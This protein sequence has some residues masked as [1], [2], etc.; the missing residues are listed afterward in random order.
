MHFLLLGLLLPFVLLL[1]MLGMERVERSLGNEAVVAHLDARFETAQR[2]EL[3]AVVS[4]GAGP[5][6]ENY[7]NRRRLSGLLLSRSQ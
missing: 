3:E 5:T 7:G 6:P 1:L 2:A 4:E